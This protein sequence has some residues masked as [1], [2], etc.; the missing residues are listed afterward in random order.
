MLS[1]EPGATQTPKDCVTL[2]K[3]VSQ[4]VYEGRYN[5]LCVRPPPGPLVLR[6]ATDGVRGPSR[7][8][9]H[10][11]SVDG[12]APTIL[13]ISE[14]GPLAEITGTAGPDAHVFFSYDGPFQPLNDRYR[15]TCRW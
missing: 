12:P 5:I 14:N 2:D 9:V 1:A 7:L 15:L 13:A 4:V 6:C 8:A 3:G 10:P 11:Y